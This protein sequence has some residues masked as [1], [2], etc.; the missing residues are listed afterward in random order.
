MSST[1]I[2]VAG[3]ACRFPGAQSVDEFWSLLA[4]NGDAIGPAPHWRGPRRPGGYVEHAECFDAEFFGI[5]TPE[6]GAMDPQQRLLLQETWHALQDAALSLRELQDFRVG[7]FVGVCSDDYAH[8]TRRTGVSGVY[9]MTGTSRTFIA[10]RVSATFGFNGPCMTVDTGQSSSLTALHLAR[11][12]MHVG[13]C[14]IAIVAGTQLNLDSVADDVLDQLG[15]LSPTYRCRTLDR[16]ADGIVRGEGIG[17]AVLTNA[18]IARHGYAELVWTEVNHDGSEGGLTVP[19]ASVQQDLLSRAYKNAGIDPTQVGYLELHGTGTRTGDP[20]EV[21]AAAGVLARRPSKGTPTLFIGSVKTNI[22]HLEAASGIAGFIKTALCIHEGNIP[23][24]LNFDEP[25]PKLRLVDGGFTVP[26]SL[27]RWQ[28]SPPDRVAGITS[29]GLGGSNVHAVL[30]GVEQS[31]GDQR[32][33]DADPF[34][35]VFTGRTWGGVRKHAAAVQE[36]LKAKRYTQSQV[37][38]LGW[39][40][41]HAPLSRCSI[42]IG[43]SDA[44]GAIREIQHFLDDGGDN[45]TP[46]VGGIAFCFPGQGTL[47]PGMGHDLYRRWPA[48]AEAFDQASLAVEKQVGFSLHDILWSEGGQH[49]QRLDR[50]QPALFGFQ[51]AMIELLRSWGLN[52]DIVLGHSQGEITAAYCAGFLTLTDACSLVATRGHLINTLPPVGLMLAVRG[53]ESTVK[54]LI[55]RSNLDLDIAGINGPAST[56]VAGPREHVRQFAATARDCHLQSHELNVARAGHCSLMDPIVDSLADVAASLPVG[57]GNTGVTL[58]SCLDGR[59]V[60]P[61]TTLWSS[62]WARHLRQTVRFTDALQTAYARGAR[63]FID[64]G[65]GHSLQA[66]VDDLLGAA[67]LSTAIAEGGGKECLSVAKTLATAASTGYRADASRGTSAGPPT[68]LTPFKA[69]RHWFNDDAPPSEEVP[70][71]ASAPLTVERSRFETATVVKELTERELESPADY[72]AERTFADMGLDSRAASAIRAAL[73]KRLSR[74]LPRTLL[75]DYPTPALLVSALMG[76]EDL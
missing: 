37:A 33:Q 42:G 58:I 48:F 75:F 23:S 65:P 30:R 22:G 40:S 14:D 16:N 35:L 43:A 9:S 47:Q 45:E 76:E 19:S 72:Q 11:T 5:S 63:W 41:L 20:I 69:S 15:V 68:A 8:L 71:E 64:I 60:K 54:C 31:A 29:L 1:T 3:L 50:S 7:V 49:L 10:N 12:S 55:E 59:V 36:T 62:H 38:G 46:E 2:R 27:V 70:Q 53:P 24:S 39:K 44:S 61:D 74:E 67:V 28:T 18:S 21:E 13:E 52:P 56:V 34:P 57:A 25:N 73:T 26:K 66:N 32:T 4:S 6:A 51:V 17:V